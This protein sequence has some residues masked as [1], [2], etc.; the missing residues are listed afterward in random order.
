MIQHLL[1]HRGGGNL[2]LSRAAKLCGGST[3][4]SAGLSFAGAYRFRRT[5]DWRGIRAGS[6]EHK[7]FGGKGGGGSVL[8]T[9]CSHHTT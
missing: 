3:L 5:T 7:K 2:G 9:I 8:S 6:N 4:A 1:Q